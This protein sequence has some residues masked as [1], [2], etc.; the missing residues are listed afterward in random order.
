METVI[1]K[2]AMIDPVTLASKIWKAVPG[3]MVGF[4]GINEDY[5]EF[6]IWDCKGLEIL[7]E[8]LAEYVQKGEKMREIIFK[9]RYYRGFGD[10]VTET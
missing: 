6:S 7:E 1:I 5:F 4:R 8:I 10:D 3:A 9:R 2:Y